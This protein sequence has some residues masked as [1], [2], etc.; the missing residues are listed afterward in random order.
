MRR[1]VKSSPKRIIRGCSIAKQ[2]VQDQEVLLR[3]QL[4][5]HLLAIVAQEADND[6]L[7]NGPALIL[8]VGRAVHLS[9]KAQCSVCVCVPLACHTGSS[10]PYSFVADAPFFLDHR[11]ITSQLCGTPSIVVRTLHHLLL[12]VHYPERRKRQQ[13][14]QPL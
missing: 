12:A 8:Q 7:D 2:L 14:R 9:A 6:A 4:Q 13:T 5:R 10:H 11:L 3:P 1:H